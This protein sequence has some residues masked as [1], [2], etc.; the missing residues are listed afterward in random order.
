[1]DATIENAAAKDGE[2]SVETLAASGN[3][4]LLMMPCPAKPTLLRRLPADFEPSASVGVPARLEQASLVGPATRALHAPR[5]RRR[6][7]AHSAMR[8]TSCSKNCPPARNAV[9]GPPRGSRSSQLLPRIK[10]QIRASRHVAGRGKVHRR[11]AL[12]IARQA[13][14]DPHGQWI[15][16]PHIEAASEAAWTGIVADEL[17]LRPRRSHLSRWA[18]AA[19]RRQTPGGSSTTRPPTPTNS[20][21]LCELSGSSQPLCAAARE[22]RG[23][24]AQLARRNNAASAPAFTIR[25]C[26][27]SIGGKSNALETQR[28]EWPALYSSFS[29]CAATLLRCRTSAPCTQ[30]MTS[31]AMLVA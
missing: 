29:F 28:Y 25:A 15:L 11:R 9:I 7:R 8:F 2:I 1:M 21:P 3:C 24:P 23:S 4:N 30:K 5:R 19:V 27:C 22:L 17:A 10:A 14:K 16:S 6:S 18:R 13:I 31:S 26:R 20:S 12:D